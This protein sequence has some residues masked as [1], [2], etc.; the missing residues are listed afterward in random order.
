M[1]TE[2]L[3]LAEEL[4]QCFWKQ[5]HPVPVRAWEPQAPALQEAGNWQNLSRCILTELAK[6]QNLGALLYKP[7]SR[8][9]PSGKAL[10]GQCHQ[11]VCSC[12]GYTSNTWVVASSGAGRGWLGGASVLSLP[13]GSGRDRAA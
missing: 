9:V 10:A 12:A 1:Q 8:K 4:E 5:S 2:T 11:G 6:L 13:G 3:I 7:T